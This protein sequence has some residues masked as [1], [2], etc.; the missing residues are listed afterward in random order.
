MLI[1]W[2]RLL[3]FSGMDEVRLNL[4]SKAMLKRKDNIL[5]G[6]F[7]GPGRDSWLT[8][9]ERIAFASIRY[10]CISP[11]YVLTYLVHEI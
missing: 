6:L 10:S 2:T 8:L 1:N 7:G 5:L 4:W 3:W 11:Q 9:M